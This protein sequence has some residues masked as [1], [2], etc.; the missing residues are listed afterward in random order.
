MS[1]HA[2]PWFFCRFQGICMYLQY[3]QGPPGAPNMEQPRRSPALHSHQARQQPDQRVEIGGHHKETRR[4]TVLM[5]WD[6]MG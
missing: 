1:Y 6:A 5:P 4:G 3:P 2:F